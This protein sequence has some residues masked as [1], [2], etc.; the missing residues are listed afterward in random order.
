MEKL[1]ANQKG[2]PRREFTSEFKSEALNLVGMSGKS[3]P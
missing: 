2:K 3:V 1:Q